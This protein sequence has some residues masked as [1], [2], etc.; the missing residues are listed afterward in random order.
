MFSILQRFKSLKAKSEWQTQVP[1]GPTG[2]MRQFLETKEGKKERRKGKKSHWLVLF[3]L[4]PQIQI[5][6]WHSHTDSL[7]EMR[8][9]NVAYCEECRDPT[10]DEGAEGWS[11]EGRRKRTAPTG[12]QSSLWLGSRDVTHKPDGKQMPIWSSMSP[13]PVFLSTLSSTIQCRQYRRQNITLNLLSVFMIPTPHCQHPRTSFPR[14]HPS[15]WIPLHGH[16]SQ[17]PSD[18]KLFKL[19]IPN[20][21]LPT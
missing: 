14:R 8:W 3:S 17:P 16:L 20:F 4:W 11:R 7:L 18:S 12:H 6:Y 15:L 13:S 1:A 5:L 9:E 21:I 2:S 10:K 19:A